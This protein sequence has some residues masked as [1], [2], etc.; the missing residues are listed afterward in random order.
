LKAAL[1]PG[2]ALPLA[3]LLGAALLAF[4]TAGLRAPGN[5]DPV[6]HL[7]YERAVQLS[8]GA[9][10]ETCAVL[11][12]QAFAH[13]A[14]RSGNDFRIFRDDARSSVEVPF[15]LTES[16]AEPGDAQPAAVENVAVQGGNTL[17]FDL[18][19][20]R[21]AYTAVELQL[22]AN[23]FTAEATVSGLDRAAGPSTP[24]GVFM[25]FDLAHEH[26]ARST[27]LPLQE[28]RFPILHVRLR[29]WG[30][31]PAATM[32]AGAT[33]PPSREA[34]TLHTVVASTTD[35]KATDEGTRSIAELEI[36]AHVPVEGVR[37]TLDPA[38]QGSFLRGVTVQGEAEDGAR[39]DV[40]GQ[41]WRVMRAAG[42]D[43]A[44]PLHASRLAI[45]AVL[46]V[47]LR[48]K[49]KITISIENGTNPPLPV[50]SVQLEMRQRMFCFNAAANAHYT[51]RYGDAGM[52][53]PVYTH[54]YLVDAAVQAQRSMLGP[55]TINPGFRQRPRTRQAGKARS[56]TF[57][58]GMLLVIT[59]GGTL[60][61]HRVRHE[62]KKA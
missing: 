18:A 41:I 37:V 32:I 49:A 10:G 25:L 24:L 59:F 7:R 42:P 31:V 17:D 39:E 4:Q 26:L 46:A 6:S 21:R 19:M 11:D 50:R 60:A 34:Q 13:M 40:Q 52:P 35:V 58:I 33:V 56:Q 1:L 53:P 62:R 57:W 48:S 47:N 27:E 30:V 51:L 54:A 43:G 2:A 36:P 20:P 16:G 55:E 28:S 23:N 22:A 44:H 8:P 14:S 38:W 29:L 45:E 15:A 9:V 61:L 5:E 3:V 12:A